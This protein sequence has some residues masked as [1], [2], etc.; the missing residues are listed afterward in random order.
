ML[1][2]PRV[3]VSL[4]ELDEHWS[5]DDLLLAHDALDVRDDIEALANAPTQKQ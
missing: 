5:V 1:T 3:G 2:D 4:R